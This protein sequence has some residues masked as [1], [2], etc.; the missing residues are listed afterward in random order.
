MKFD[1]QATIQI[2]L[3]SIEAARTAGHINSA[4]ASAASYCLTLEGDDAELA[5]RVVAR[6]SDPLSLELLA[7][8]AA[9]D[10]VRAAHYAG[11]GVYSRDDPERRHYLALCAL[12]HDETKSSSLASRVLDL[13]QSLLD[14]GVLDDT[15]EE[16]RATYLADCADVEEDRIMSTPT[17]VLEVGG[18]M[19]PVGTSDRVFAK[20]YWSGEPC[21]GVYHVHP[22][23]GPGI[24]VGCDRTTLEEQEVVCEKVI[25]PDLGVVTHPTVLDLVRDGLS[26]A[27]I[28]VPE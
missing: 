2:I 19:M 22:V 28:E 18:V 26:A 1:E 15:T 20:V 6:G 27:G 24:L 14:L 17:T 4:A 12:S 21:A 11:P 13:A 23:E 10:K 3:N 25:K 5:N 7:N 9:S 8:G 16:D